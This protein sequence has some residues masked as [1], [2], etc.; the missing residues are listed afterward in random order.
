LGIQGN[1]QHCRRAGLPEM[2]FD[3]LERRAWRADGLNTLNF[4]GCD[5]GRINCIPISLG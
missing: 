1:G 3:L 2:Q 5:N 4:G